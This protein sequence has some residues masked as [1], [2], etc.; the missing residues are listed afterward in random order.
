MDGSPPAPISSSTTSMTPIS[1]VTLTVVPPAEAPSPAVA[2]G[3]YPPGATAPDC[4][5]ETVGAVTADRLRGETV[6]GASE[7]PGPS[8]AGA[9]PGALFGALAA[10]AG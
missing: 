7:E 6:H 9:R 2:G 3:G 5:A 10:T 8:S 1:T 4:G